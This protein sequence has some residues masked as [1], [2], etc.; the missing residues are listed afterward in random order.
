MDDD[1]QPLG[2]DQDRKPNAAI[3]I[4][5]EELVLKMLSSRLDLQCRDVVRDVSDAVG[6]V[7]RRLCN[8]LT[9][10]SR[11]IFIMRFRPPGVA[12]R[13]CCQFLTDSAFSR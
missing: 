12:E 5:V 6:E 8:R 9:M 1:D 11:R 2:G 10:N 7:K 3:Q 4:L 13:L